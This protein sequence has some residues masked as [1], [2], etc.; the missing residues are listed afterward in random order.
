MRI[1]FVSELKNKT[2]WEG[3]S[4]SPF[5]ILSYLPTSE[6]GSS[7]LD[8]PPLHSNHKA[9]EG[10]QSWYPCPHTRDMEPQPGQLDTHFSPEGPAGRSYRD[11]PVQR[12][13]WA[14][15]RQERQAVGTIH[16]RKATGGPPAPLSFFKTFLMWTIF[17][18]FLELAKYCFCFIF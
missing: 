6:E 10:L 8:D 13:K 9:V 2:A 18:V 11:A 5:L 16:G 17:K 15:G 3:L 4:L 12:M 7:S 1:A 14:F